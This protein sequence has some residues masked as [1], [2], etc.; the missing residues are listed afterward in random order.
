MGW[1]VLYSTNDSYYVKRPCIRVEANVMAFEH[2]RRLSGIQL[3]PIKPLK[4]QV[5]HE[6]LLIGS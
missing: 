1:F 4:I 6:L 5:N 3:D 2:K